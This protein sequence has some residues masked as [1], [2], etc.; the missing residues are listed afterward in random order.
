MA[1]VAIIESVTSHI[2]QPRQAM[3]LYCVR[4]GET[5]HNFDRSHRRSIR[6]SAHSLGSPAVP[7][8][9]R[10]AL[11]DSRSTP[12]IAS[13]LARARESAQMIAERLGLE[14]QFEPR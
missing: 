3:F 1:G 14:V 10:S 13:P 11:S 6:Q 7:G 8:R 12:S 2:H 4:H 5:Q 9:G